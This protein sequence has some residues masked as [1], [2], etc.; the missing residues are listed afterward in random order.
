MMKDNAQSSVGGVLC[1]KRGEVGAF[2]FSFSKWKK[3]KAENQVFRGLPVDVITSTLSFLLPPSVFHSNIN[4]VTS[5]NNNNNN[6]ND[7]DDSQ[8]KCIKLTR[9]EINEIE[10][11]KIKSLEVEMWAVPLYQG[12]QRG[13]PD[14]LINEIQNL[15]GRRQILT[16]KRTVMHSPASTMLKAGD[17]IL[18]INRSYLSSFMDVTRIISKYNKRTPLSIIIDGNEVTQPIVDA[19]ISHNNN[20]SGSYDNNDNN[21]NSI[22]IHI[23]DNEENKIDNDKSEGEVSIE[24]KAEGNNNN[25]DSNN[26]NEDVDIVTTTTMTVITTTNTSTT[27]ISTTVADDD[28]DEKIEEKGDDDEDEGEEKNE[29]EENVEDEKNEGDAIIEKNDSQLQSGAIKEKR[30][31][32]KREKKTTRKRDSK[33]KSSSSLVVDGDVDFIDMKIWRKNSV[34]NI[35]IALNKFVLFIIITIIITIIKRV[36]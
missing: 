14:R 15:N 28:D 25:E 8:K 16:V 22:D 31:K 3:D 32:K 24:G 26:N 1:N 29:G 27:I 10:N 2:W 6:I 33:K 18:S 23:C 13:L 34:K 11:K 20:N 30:S 7:D 5:D 4:I 12:R 17:L 21:D 9:E 19:D 36:L 35:R